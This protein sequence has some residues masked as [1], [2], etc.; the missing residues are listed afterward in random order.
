MRILSVLS[1]ILVLLTL[2]AF[3][4]KDYEKRGDKYFKVLNYDKAL[5][6]YLRAY[7]KDKENPTLLAKISECYLN[8]NQLKYQAIPYLEKLKELK[9]RDTEI[10]Y[11]L[12]EAYLHA[13]K[14]D[15]AKEYLKM[16]ESKYEKNEYNDEKI[17]ILKHYID[18]AK[19]YTSE[20][21]IV[22]L[23]NLG[24]KINTSRSELNPY[25]TSDETILFFSSDKR[26]NS[27]GGFYYFNLCVSEMQENGWGKYKTI[28]STV[29]SG[30]DEIVA[31]I[32]PSGDEVFIFHNRYGDEVIGYA[33]YKGK[34]RFDIMSDFGY[35]IDMKGGEY[36]VC[37]TE[38]SD[39]LIYAAE[40]LS[41]SIDLFYSIKLP[42]G[43]WGESRPLP[44]KIN[45]KYDE[46]FPVYMPEEKRIY[47]SS[48]N[49][50]SMGGYDLFYSDLDTVTREWKEPVNLGYPVNDTYDNYTISWVK[51]KRIGY[52]SAVR[53][54]GFGNRDIYKVV[55]V[56]KDPSNAI[57]KCTLRVKTDS[58]EVVPWFTPK[59]NVFDTLE[60]KVGTYALSTDSARFI[61]ALPPGNYY[62]RI[63][64]PE[65]ESFTDTISIPERLYPP[66]PK[67][68][69]F[70]L[71]Q[72]TEMQN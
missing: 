54:E 21:E 40:G 42:T 36:G 44:G 50:K 20:P 22:D 29:N 37:M 48:N 25:V 3:S 68:K 35:P 71:E 51:G 17:F 24:N 41:G 27:Y 8:G 47:F 18:N 61:M 57:F 63:D 23:I 64:A 30:Y 9:P 58:A 60:L 31:G 38:G 2:M 13:L 52:I 39:T 26:Y 5:K 11:Y 14:F 4:S 70:I 1:V 72:K 7:R 66:V 6:E 10:L 69:R 65:I 43:E 56:K 15:K 59:I 67:E 34:Y 49:T 53:P 46:N 62:L 33:K 19:K 28:G 12:S 16:Y 32:N 45:S 55:Y